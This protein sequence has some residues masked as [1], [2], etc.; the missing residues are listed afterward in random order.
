MGV[1]GYLGD[2]FLG[3]P[4]AEDEAAAAAVLEAK[5]KKTNQEDA[6]KAKVKYSFSGNRNA[7][8]PKERL[9]YPKDKIYDE[10]TDY[11]SFQ[12]VK[13]S[14]PF[15]AVGEGNKNVDKDGKQKK[16]AGAVNV[17]NN[18]INEFVTAG[19]PNIAMYMPE[20]IGAEYGSQWGGKGFTN[21][22]ADIMRVAGAVTNS[23]NLGTSASK[24][25]DGL[26][27]FMQRGPALVADSI[28][29]ATNSLPGKIGGS[30]DANDVLGSIGGVILNPNV[31]LLFTGFEMRTFGLD[32]IMAPKTKKEAE[33]IRDIVTTFKRASLPRLGASP[34]NL[35]NN[36]FGGASGEAEE[37]SNS[38]F[39]GVPNLCIVKFMKGA[40]EHPY[41]VQYKPCAI[42][43][44]KIV[45][46]PDGA[47]TTYRDGS[48]VATKLTVTFAETKL[49]YSNEISY[50][51]ASY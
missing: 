44:V 5:K 31:E 28:A 9:T 23:N 27:N 35:V 51:G 13:Y 11:V 12:F 50:G 37:N 42:T 39:I 34:G 2:I 10:F 6:G 19:L 33:M 22:G 15:A 3:M 21:T 38:N 29:T 7:K 1:L 47:Y 32:F 43:N 18:N 30:I 41:L 46:T 17:Y 49:V 48:P 20:D 40:A 8:V 36:V 25:G 45:Y 16:D 26:K 14:P 24:V 4:S